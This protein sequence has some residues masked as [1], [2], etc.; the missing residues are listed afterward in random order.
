[1]TGDLDHMLGTDS[2]GRDI[3]ARII[4][5]ARISLLVGVSAV[6]MSGSIGVT[7][8][9]VAGYFR[10]RWDS[11]IMRLADVQ[12]AVP[13]MV[14]AL[15][16][17]AVVGPGLRN[18]III[19][20]VT[21]WVGYARVV[22]GEVL[23][24]REKEFVEAARAIGASHGRILLLHLLPNV[25]ASIIVISSLRVA[26]MILVEASLSFLGLGVQ[27]PTPTWGGMVAEGRDLVYRAWWVSTFP[28]IAIFIVVLG[29]NLLG[30][31][32]RDVLD[33]RLRT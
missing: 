26:G 8:G 12:L 11:I 27:P 7:L 28:G 23:S 4:Y 19:L 22:R 33:P 1:M 17:M 18:L 5:G 21:G 32:L 13:T 3:L 16:A 25:A 29:I 14:L 31:W 24:I 6:T 9:L 15:V 30:D 10:G 2:L 20:G